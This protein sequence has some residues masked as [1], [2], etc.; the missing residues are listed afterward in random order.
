[1]LGLLALHLRSSSFVGLTYF[2]SSFTVVRGNSGPYWPNDGSPS[3][4][5]TGLALPYGLPKL[6]MHT[7]KNLDISKAFPAPPS[8]GPHQSPTSA[9]P[10]R[11]WH[12]TMALSPAG[13]SMP[14]V[15]YAT[16]TLRRTA[17][18]SRANSGMMANV[19]SGISAANG[20]SGCSV[21]LPEI[22][23]LLA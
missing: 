2:T 6:L 19:W 13:E 15:L 22:M 12:M 9:L 17:P 11:A 3:L 8:I 7:T 16:G 4:A 10:V 23:I 21:T 14:Y 1:M 18:D 5:V 20:F